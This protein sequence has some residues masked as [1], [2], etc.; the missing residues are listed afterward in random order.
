[1][2]YNSQTTVVGNLGADPELRFTPSGV[3]VAT[4]NVGVGERR[5][6][7]SGE[8]EDAGTSWYRVIIWNQ[9]AEN[10]AESLTRGMRVMV[11]GTMRSRNYETKEGE[12][13]TVWEL[14]ADEIGPTLRGQT[15]TVN[16][17]ARERPETDPWAAEPAEPPAASE[18]ASEPAT[19][20]ATEPV[21]EP[22]T[23]PSSGPDAA[24]T[25]RGRGRSRGKHVVTA[26]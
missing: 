18:P 1:M 20:P 14:T 17:A 7:S 3:P 4:L 6:N 24:S 22:A 19:E 11:T 23:E 26:P 13:R 25:G 8:W 16:R 12:K 21:S 10:V 15:V 5:R 2:T 9:S